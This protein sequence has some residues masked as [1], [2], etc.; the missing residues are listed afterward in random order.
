MMILFLAFAVQMVILLNTGEKYKWLRFAPFIA[1]E[2]YPLYQLWWNRMMY[3][4]FG[5]AY[6]ESIIPWYGLAILAGYVLA[7]FIYAVSSKRNVEE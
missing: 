5:T 1:A 6:A 3:A 2:V 7:W 4:K